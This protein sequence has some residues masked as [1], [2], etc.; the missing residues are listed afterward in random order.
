[1][2]PSLFRAG[3]GRAMPNALARSAAAGLALAGIAAA[4]AAGGDRPTPYDLINASAAR[5]PITV[6]R[7]R[8]NVVMLE[9]SGGNIGVLAE[10][11]GLLMVD[12]GIAVSEAKIKAAL[13]AISPG[14]LKTV[15]LTHWHWDHSDGD[16]WVRRARATLMADPRAI[17]RLQQT[18]RIVEW[19]HTFT[20]VAL[21]SQPND[22]VA[23]DR[24]IPFG[25]ETVAVRHYRAGHTDGDLSVYFRRADILQTGDTFWNGVYPFIDYVTGGSIDGAIAAANENLRL[26]GAQTMVIPGH[27]PAGDRAALIAFRD[28]LVTVRGRVAALKAQGKSLDEVLAAHP[29]ADLDA[30]WGQS[31]IDGHLFTALV[32]RGV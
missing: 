9:G 5:S 17:E 19:G 21:D 30:R 32:Y 2:F 28:M 4:P 26:A 25:G 13:K 15:I 18:N 1:M 14:P 20:P 31:V 29:T 3:A 27:G 11:G 7:L 12:A 23:G 22:S 16:A 6:H 8:G 10:P 24:D